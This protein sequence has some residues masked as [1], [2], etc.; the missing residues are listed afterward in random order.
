ML[1]GRSAMIIE[2]NKKKI[3]VITK[4]GFFVMFYNTFNQTSLFSFT[5]LYFCVLKNVLFFC[6]CLCLLFI[7]SVVNKL[8]VLQKYNKQT[9]MWLYKRVELI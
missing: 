1:I 7:S 6:C 4:N 9:N 8:V 2:L 5:K 3:N